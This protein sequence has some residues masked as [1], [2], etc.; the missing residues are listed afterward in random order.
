MDTDKLTALRSSLLTSDDFHAVM[1]RFHRDLG[2]ETAFFEAGE[3]AEPGVL[4]PVLA[5][6]AKR[7]FGPSARV[8]LLALLRLREHLF[9]HGCLATAGRLGNVI[10]FEDVQTGL[11]ALAGDNDRVECVRFCT[12][13]VPM[14]DAGRDREPA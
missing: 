5:K 8:E 6:I 14:P 3:P 1:K 10:Y 13:A 12:V 11:V 7:L 9:V 2:A 4:G